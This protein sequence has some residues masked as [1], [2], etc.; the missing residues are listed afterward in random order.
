MLAV[1][2]TKKFLLELTQSNIH[3][4]YPAHCT[5]TGHMI[6]VNTTLT[7]LSVVEV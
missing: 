3:T 2:K 7:A 5:S 4:L 1:D 6:S